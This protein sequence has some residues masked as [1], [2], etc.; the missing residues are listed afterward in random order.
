MKKFIL[1]F[2]ALT[3]FFSSFSQ[4]VPKIKKSEF[5]TV[6][7]GF[8]E[9]WKAFKKGHRLFKEKKKG[10]FQ[11][12]IDYLNQAYDYNPD[13]A[14][15]VYELGISYLMISDEKN[16]MKFL[17]DAF[18]LNPK[19]TPDIHFWLGRAYHLNYR[20]DDA[21]EEYEMYQ[22]SLDDKLLKKQGPAIKKLIDECETGKELVAH[23]KN[24]IITNLGENVNTQWPEYAPVFASYDS[25]VFFTSRRPNTT[26]GKRN[27]KVSNEYYEDIYFTSALNG[28]WQKPGQFGKPVNSKKNDA[29]IGVDKTGKVLLIYRG[30]EK[31]SMY[32]TTYNSMKEK[33]SRPKNVIRRLNK[34]KTKESTLTFS[35]DSTTVYFVSNRKGGFGKKDIWYSKKRGLSNSGW[36]K[37]VNLG[38]PINTKYDEEAVFLMGDDKTMYFASKGHNTMGGYDIFKTVKQPDGRWSEPQ[39][40][41][42]PINTPGD[43]LFFFM[44]PDKR[45]GYFASNGQADSYGDFDIYEF[46]FYTPKEPLGDNSPDDL[47]AYLK[48]PVSEIVLEDP[49]MIKTMRLVL[50]K[51]QIYEWENHKPIAGT[52]DII[53]DIT[54]EVEQQAKANSNGE[55]STT[56]IPGKSYTLIAWAKGYAKKKDYVSLPKNTD[57]TEVIRNFELLPINPGAKAKLRVYFETAKATLKPESF[58][59]LDRFAQIMKLYPGLI[60]EIQGHTDSRGS[61]AYNLKLS[62]ARADAVRDYLISKGIEPDRLIAKGYGES[63]PVVPNDTPEHMAMNRRVEAHIIANKEVEE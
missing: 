9:A 8:D 35:H 34:R 39:N 15:L 36:S 3:L 62:Q 4:T 10:S 14:P 58:P 52:V 38:K 44:N 46:F 28:V 63:Q 12:A 19:L 37:P 54:G 48:E 40:L 23:P 45:T 57:S 2:V 60:V 30:K 20:F 29:S 42:Y 56:I 24:V 5:F 18:D 25:V 13:Y 7:N 55:Y 32:I 11:Q 59:E 16:A 22:N 41:G 33:W 51:G 61:E 27:F 17:E 50:L 53:N 21:I 31:G 1:L 49:V 43:D 6:E 47:I 26:G